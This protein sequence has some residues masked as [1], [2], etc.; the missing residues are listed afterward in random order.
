MKFIKKF[1]EMKQVNDFGCVMVYFNFENWDKIQ[2]IIKEE[3]LYIDPNDPSYGREEEPHTTLLYG[4]HDIDD[5]AILDDLKSIEMPNIKI[6]DVSL[7]ENDDF[8][9]LKFGLESEDLFKLNKYFDNKY[10]NSNEYEYK[11]HCTI[12]YLLPGKGKSYID[13]I[14]TEQIFSS[15]KVVYSKIDGSKLEFKIK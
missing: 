11:P 2:D 8:D 10:P 9:V 4:I 12:A 5:S 3:D 6:K 13:K 1:K 14:T 7:F 15:D